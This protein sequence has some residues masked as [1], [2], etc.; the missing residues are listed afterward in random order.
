MTTHNGKRALVLGGS[1]G[2]LTTG[3]LLREQGFDVTIF[4]R[5]S[6][7]LGNRGG[8][9]VLQPDTLRWFRERSSISPEEVST[10]TQFLRYLGDGNEIVFEEKAEWQ[11]SSWS[12]MYNS[13]LADF[14]RE[15]YVLGE[16]AVGFDQDVDGVDVRFVS[17]R[18]ERADLVVFADG[19]TSV[20]RRR[21]YPEADLSYSGYIGWRGTVLESD[22]SAATAELLGSS[23]TYSVGPNTHIC[24]YP[25]PGPDNGFEVG[26][27]LL[28]YVWYR[29]VAE[30]PE[31]DEI[32]TDKRGFIG[33]VS[34]HPGQVQDR[35]ITEMKTAAKE[36]LAP[37]AAELV[38]LTAEPYIQPVLDVRSPRMVEGRVVLIGDAAFA[39]R[40]HAAAAA[41]KAAADAWALA[42]A[43]GENESITT[44]LAK[45]EP[46]RLQLGNN[47]IDR[48]TS[49]GARSQFQ[50][51]W[52]PGDPE[53][54]F[55]LYGPGE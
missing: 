50:N 29:N 32:L 6:T 22:V 49:M 30:G 46:G 24:M 37:A 12:V 10:S 45:W 53:L 2:G 17:G 28:N 39:A 13:L 3:L 26:K 20:G 54:R 5:T 36:L 43:L 42:E 31:L 48:V 16:Y 35:Y 8:G 19:I 11:Y 4:E 14:G 18:N 47:L 41:A 33:S 21:L 44:A 55:G 38:N 1:V 34:V 9:I 25:I 7:E 27:R 15:S 51:T 52:T 23:L 40:P